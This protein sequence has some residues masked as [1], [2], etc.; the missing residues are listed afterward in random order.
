MKILLIALLFAGAALGRVEEWSWLDSVSP[1]RRIDDTAFRSGREYHFFYNGQLST[2]IAGSSKQHSANRI[3]SLVI[4]AFKSQ[5]HVLMRLQNLRMGKMNR[6]VPNPRK[7][8]PFDAFE[9]VEIEQH[10]KQKLERVVKFTY[11][12]GLVHDVVF[13]AQEDPWSANIKRGV[14]NLLQVN[15]QQQRRLDTQED[16]K[17]TNG[18]RDV[19]RGTED[20]KANFYRV[21]EQTLEGECE[22]LYTIQQQPNQNNR[23][24]NQPVL[25][26]T[27]SINFEKCNKRPQIKYNF[28]FADN[29]PTC[30]SKYNDDEKFLKSST[31]A[32]YNITGDKQAFLIEGARVDSEY[33]FVPF[34]EEAN[35][36]VTYVNQT[37]V[38]IKTGPTQNLHEP[39]NPVESDSDMIFSL[40]WDVAY[41]KFHMNGDNQ[42]HH[43]LHESQQGLNKVELAKKFVQKMIEKM[44]KEQLDDDML[45]HYTRLVQLMRMCK[46]DELE[47]IVR[48]QSSSSTPEHEKKLKTI[49]PQ[50]LG[51]CGTKTCTKLLVQKIRQGEITPLRGAFAVKHLLHNRVVSTDII[52]ELIQLA[53]SEKARES[54]HLKRN[55]WLTVGSLINALCTENED[56]LA[57]ETKEKGEKLCPRELKDQYVKTLFSKL[58]QATKWQDK[59]LMLKTIGNAGLE[60]SIFELEKIIRQQDQTNH[61]MH[62][63][64]EAILALRQLKDSVP[65]KIQRILMPVI[66]NRREYP[67]IRSTASYIL[68]QTMPERSI[69]DQLAHNLVTETSHQFSAFLYTQM[70]SYANSTNPCEKRV[71]TDMKLALRHAKKISAGFGY[72]RMF[73]WSMHSEQQ[74]LGLDADFDAVYSNISSIPRHVGLALHANGLGFWQKY[75]ATLNFFNE[76]LEPLIRQYFDADTAPEFFGGSSEDDQ[77]RT[78]HP[79]S[80]TNNRQHPYQQ[81]MNDIFSKHLKVRARDY[82]NEHE[83]EPKAYVSASFKGQSVTL[84]PIT[85]EFIEQLIQDSGSNVRQ[86]EQKLRQGL[87]IDYTTV[88]EVHDMQYKVPTTLGMPLTVTIKA[89]IAWSLK[90]TLKT[91]MDPSSKT[92]KIQAQLKPSAVAQVLCKVEAWSPIVNTGIKIKAKAKLFTP[93]DARVEIDYSTKPYT[94]KAAIKPSTQKRDLLVLETRPISYTQDW[95]RYVKTVDEGQDEKTIMGEEQNRV[96]TFTKCFGRQTLGIEL[97]ARGQVHRTPVQS[98]VGTP[99]S[100]LSGPNKIVITS[101]PGQDAPEEIHIKLSTKFEQLS[102][103]EMRKP[104]FS[105]FSLRP[106][107]NNDQDSSSSSSE[108]VDD[109]QDQDQSRGSQEQQRRR[110]GHQQSQEQQQQQSQRRRG[111]QSPIN[112][113]SGRNPQQSQRSTFNQVLQQYRNYEMKK[114]YKTRVQLEMQAGQNRKVNLELSHVY[115]IKQRYAQVNMKLKRD[116]PDQWEACLDAE[117]MFPER[118][119]FADDVKDKKA[120]ASAQL[121]WGQSCQSSQNFIQ[122]TTRAERSRQQMDWERRQNDFQQYRTS[123]CQNKAWCSP[124]TQEDFVEKIGQMLKYRVDIDYQNVPSTV[125]NL[126]NKLYRALK[127]YYYWQTDVDQFIQNPSNKIRA[128]I[129]LD[130]QTKQ[131][132]NITLQTPKESIKIQD[133]PLSQPLGVMNQKQSMSEQLREYVSDDENPNECSITGKKGLQRRSQVETFDGTKFTAPFTNCWV[134]L[135][136]DC[137]SEQPKFVVMARKSERHQDL[138]EVKILTKRHRIQLSPET[139]EYESIKVDVNGQTY[140]LEQQDRDIVENGQI[141]AQIEKDQSTVQVKLP[142]TGVEVEFD[143]YAINIK[144]SDTYRGQQCGLCGHFDLESVDEFRNPDFSDERDIRQFYMNYLIKDGSCQAPQQLNEVCESEECDKDDRSSSSSSSSS[145]GSQEDSGSNEEQ[146]TPEYKTKVIEMDDQLCFSTVPIPLCDEEDSYPMG[147]K[148]QKKVSYV[149]IDQDSQSA[150]DIERLARSGRSRDIQALKNR[151]P[152][153]T[154]TENVPEKCKKYNKN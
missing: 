74:K 98:V 53:D 59:V 80:A 5:N 51:N 128:E 137:S 24:S 18:R 77:I 86:V 32:K 34:N 103:S 129:V 97:C 151:T 14:L 78:R 79:R 56:Q 94:V 130:A 23:R 91:N 39:Q 10:L 100:P 105:Q 45:Q 101:E 117:M 107:S 116:R 22:T 6:D 102:G 9:D 136:K 58:R 111:A 27:K 65:K 142:K 144:L 48:M 112:R 108:I 20:E 96:S 52:T 13:D 4:V 113:R 131:R 135:A 141:V 68:L 143:G 46:E 84:V 90:G 121:K 33:V 16:V 62:V 8:M 122:M 150:E 106:E 67:T 2:G 60:L 3:Q 71:A 127:H 72:S 35:A 154:R 43:K 38:L 7:I 75:L 93:V 73:H 40:D 15:L 95:Q 89:P 124:L 83:N 12:G 126:T 125:K 49:I 37:L 119:Q 153:F 29:C 30:E 87:P 146:E 41:E 140:D 145:S 50:A 109:D 66:M 152:T 138:K 115:D 120:L 92:F 31:V 82:R 147:V 70:Q 123:K 11:T 114:G 76:G 44:S 1:N 81:E 110:G 134:V 28:R 54:E 57:L 88:V 132:L 19:R 99:F 21:M 47:Q 139:Q 118:P 104:S 61:P 64:F 133:L 148:Q 25:N 85:K 42:M 55:C 63:R 26:V 17:L 149:C 69:L 36:I